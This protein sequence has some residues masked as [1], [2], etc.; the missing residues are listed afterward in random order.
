M[1]FFKNFRENAADFALNCFAAAIE[2][3]AGINGVALAQIKAPP[4]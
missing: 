3:V 4:T 1:L 2:G